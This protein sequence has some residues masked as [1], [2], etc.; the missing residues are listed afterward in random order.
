MSQT[1]LSNVRNENDVECSENSD[2]I[3]RWMILTPGVDLPAVTENENCC[4]H[5]THL[6]S[7]KKD[8]KQ[9]IKKKMQITIDQEEEFG[10]NIEKNGINEKNIILY[11]NIEM[12][13][14]EKCIRKYENKNEMENKDEHELLLPVIKQMAI[15]GFNAVLVIV[16][17]KERLNDCLEC[18]ICQKLL[19][20]VDDDSRRVDEINNDVLE[21][22]LG[23]EMNRK[24]N[25]NFDT[26]NLENNFS[27]F[28]KNLNGNNNE[29]EKQRNVIE[30]KEEEEKEKINEENKDEIIS[31]KKAINKILFSIFEDQSSLIAGNWDSPGVSVDKRFPKYTTDNGVF[32]FVHQIEEKFSNIENE[33]HN[34]ENSEISSS[35]L[36]IDINDETDFSLDNQKSQ[37]DDN[38]VKSRNRKAPL[39]VFAIKFWS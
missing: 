14:F 7:I 18:G 5:K 33:I 4:D 1:R 35:N 21:D 29:N 23:G 16:D 34:Y 9:E 39:K 31:V 6:L 24:K 8:V 38:L 11:E 12:H 37:I 20:T 15:L 36:S 17:R 13:C 22:D 26:R 3:N 30:G 19:I 28:D 10:Q 32:H 27:H 25:N 2:D